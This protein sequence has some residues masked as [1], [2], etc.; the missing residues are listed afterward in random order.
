[1]QIAEN[2]RVAAMAG[3][4]AEI[5]VILIYKTE[6]RNSKERGGCL[7]LIMACVIT[8][9]CMCVCVCNYGEE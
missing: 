4:R 6:H 7:G 8:Y 2:S 9:V 1:M 3:W 5:G